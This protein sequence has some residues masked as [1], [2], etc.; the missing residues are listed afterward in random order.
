MPFDWAGLS[1]FPLVAISAMVRTSRSVVSNS[2]WSCARSGEKEGRK[3]GHSVENVFA[4]LQIF[5]LGAVA[6]YFIST[7]FTPWQLCE[8]KSVRHGCDDEERGFG[9]HEAC[10]VSGLPCHFVLCLFYQKMGTF[11]IWFRNACGER[12]ARLA[13]TAQYIRKIIE[14][15]DCQ[16]AV[17]PITVTL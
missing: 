9:I 6:G 5:E 7:R 15:F 12:K 1:I 14:T 16:P 10:P 17:A 3:E 13:P 11:A 8:I 4:H 2:L